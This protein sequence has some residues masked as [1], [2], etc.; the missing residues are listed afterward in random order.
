MADTTNYRN[1]M[2]RDE[3]A[4][5][6][7]DLAAELRGTGPAEVQVGNKLLTLTPASTVEYDIE[8]EERSPMLRGDREEITVSIGWEVPK[9]DNNAEDIE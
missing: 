6:V 2:T 5:L 1:D 7:A 4:D 3:A 9:G 8:V